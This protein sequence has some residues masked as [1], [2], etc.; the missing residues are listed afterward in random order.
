MTHPLN[1]YGM[2]QTIQND[3]KCQGRISLLLTLPGLQ[4]NI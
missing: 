3:A 1:M 4:I 2:K